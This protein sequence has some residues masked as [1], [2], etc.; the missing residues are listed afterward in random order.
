MLD[1]YRTKIILIIVMFSSSKINYDQ[2]GGLK[3]SVAAILSKFDQNKQSA[4]Q[5]GFYQC[6]YKQWIVNFW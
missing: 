1:K 3:F 4:G 6:K 2:R 5:E